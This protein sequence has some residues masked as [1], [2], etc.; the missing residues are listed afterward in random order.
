MLK[1]LNEAY[2]EIKDERKTTFDMATKYRYHSDDSGTSRTV[3]EIR[4]I[5]FFD[6]IITTSRYKLNRYFINLSRR[7]DRKI[8]TYVSNW[9]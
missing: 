4:P 5:P 3:A 6:E 7:I 8:K 9:K 1:C 2:C